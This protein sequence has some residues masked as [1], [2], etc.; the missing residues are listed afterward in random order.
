[1]IAGGINSMLEV[2]GQKEDAWEEAVQDGFVESLL[3]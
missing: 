2:Q 1:M 3:L